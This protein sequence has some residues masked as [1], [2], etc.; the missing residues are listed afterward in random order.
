[1]IFVV[2]VGDRLVEGGSAFRDLGRLALEVLALLLGCHPGVA[3]A[4]SACLANLEGGLG[5]E[6]ASLRAAFC[7]LKMRWRRVSKIVEGLGYLLDVR[8]D[9][10]VAG[11]VVVEERAESRVLGEVRSHSRSLVLPVLCRRTSRRTRHCRAR[12]RHTRRRNRCHRRRLSR[13]RTRCCRPHRRCT[14]RWVIHHVSC[15]RR[16]GSRY[17]L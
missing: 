7:E 10:V 17:P 12:R 4:A 14:L 13:C 5:H 16:P 9:V 2:S 1:M 3:A 6:L 15:G 8:L 11:E